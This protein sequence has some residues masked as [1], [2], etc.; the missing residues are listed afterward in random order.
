MKDICFLYLNSLASNQIIVMGTKDESLFQIIKTSH[1]L[2]NKIWF[3]NWIGKK[4]DKQI[5]E[6]KK[7]SLLLFKQ[8]TRGL[9]QV[10]AYKKRLWKYKIHPSIKKTKVLLEKWVGEFG[11]CRLSLCVSVLPT[12]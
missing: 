4:K 3:S 5:Y 11:N 6:W 7:L 12:V 10:N 1:N 9:L 2:E 8:I